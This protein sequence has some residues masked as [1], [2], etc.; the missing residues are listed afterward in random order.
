MGVEQKFK[1]L[2]LLK[3]KEWYATVIVISSKKIKEKENKPAIILCKKKLSINN[4]IVHLRILKIIYIY[5][6]G[7]SKFISQGINVWIHL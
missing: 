1:T 5:I 3:D 7:K 6:F 4:E 2:M